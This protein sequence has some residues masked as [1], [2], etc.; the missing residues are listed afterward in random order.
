MD[1]RRFGPGHRRPDG[2]PGTRGVAGQAIHQDARGTVAELAFGPHALMAPHTNANTTYFI[3]V[4]GGGFVQVGEERARVSHGEAV[5]WPAGEVHAAW[6]DG[7]EM[8]AL[9]VEFAGA[10]DGW[11]QRAS[12]PPAADGALTGMTAG[13]AEAGRGELAEPPAEPPAPA[14]PGER[15]EPSGEPW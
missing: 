3:I 8:R 10:D 6:T 15:A 4:S 11:V 14:G 7:V 9:V 12:V 1:I 2:P 13:A 5:L